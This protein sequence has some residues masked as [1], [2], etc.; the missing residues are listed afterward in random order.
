[1]TLTYKEF[2]MNKHIESSDE[3]VTSISEM[4]RRA[5]GDSIVEA[6]KAAGL[7][8]TYLGDSLFEVEE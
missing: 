7:Q 4:L 1:M 3:L 5:D 2:D 8:V 6:A